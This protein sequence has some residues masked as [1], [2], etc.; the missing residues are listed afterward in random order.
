[1][2]ERGAISVVSGRRGGDDRRKWWE[3]LLGGAASG[4]KGDGTS[5][6]GLVGALGWKGGEAPGLLGW[7]AHAAV[8]RGTGTSKTRSQSPFPPPLPAGTSAAGLV[9]ARF[10]GKGDRH[11]EDSEPV[12]V[13]N[14]AVRRNPCKCALWPI[15]DRFVGK[16]DRHLEDSEPVPVSNCAVRGARF[17]GKG[18]RHLEDSE[19]VPLSNCA[20]RRNPCK[21]ALWPIGDRFVGK[22]DRHLEDSEP[23]PVSNCAVRRHASLERGTGTSKTRSQSPFPT[24]LSGRTLRWKGG[25]APRRLGASPPFQLRCQAQPL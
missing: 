8:E 17:V 5:A 22:G 6:A 1:M 9:G 19:P 15:G 7:W 13:S 4:K 20:V 25:Q 21:C 23:V 18:D 10:V 11:L 12:P 14:C 16:G 2:K 3:S 24:A